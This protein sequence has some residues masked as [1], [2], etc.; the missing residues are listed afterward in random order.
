MIDFGIK[1]SRPGFDVNTATP[2]Q[3]AFSSKYKTFKIHERGN[4]TVNSSVSSGLITIPH[5]LDYV[6]AFLVHVDPSQTGRYCIAPYG[7]SGTQFISAY[8]DSSNLYIKAIADT[9]SNVYYLSSSVNESMAREIEGAGYFAGGWSVGNDS[10]DYYRYGAVRF[11]SIGL[12]KAESFLTATLGLYVDYNQY[13][14]GPVKMTMWGI[15]E[16]NTAAFNSGTPATARAKTTASDNYEATISQGNMWNI[17]VTDQVSEIINRGSWS[18]N[19]AIGFMFWDNATTAGR[20]YGQLNGSYSNTNL[21]I[22][23][24]TATVAD[25]KYTIFKNQLV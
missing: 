19:N 1:I 10:S 5:N 20:V 18:L 2:E 23:K 12:N 9:S 22:I 16:D 24:S 11:T 17:D 3:L 8:A 21:T 4:G 14:N 25:Y 6:P 15:D 13:S 7:S